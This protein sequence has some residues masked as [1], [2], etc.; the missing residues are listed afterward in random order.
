MNTIETAPQERSILRGLLALLFW[1]V[2]TSTLYAGAMQPRIVAFAY[3]E[4]SPMSY[5]L[6]I[7]EDSD[8]DGIY[9][10]RFVREPD[11]RWTMNCWPSACDR[12]IVQSESILSSHHEFIATYNNTWGIYTWE[13]REY[14]AGGDGQPIAVLARTRPNEYRYDR[15]GASEWSSEAEQRS[16]VTATVHNGELVVEYSS[17]A[18]GRALATI[19][20]FRGRSITRKAYTPINANQRVTV[21]IPLEDVPAG[22]HAVWVADEKGIHATQFTL[23]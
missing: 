17:G 3:P 21:R 20:N 18:P 16:T 13:L 1:S 22:T 11:G 10:T 12:R 8:G 7:T 6:E 5:G 14:R 4:G 23:R 15:S 19:A 9:D 2:C